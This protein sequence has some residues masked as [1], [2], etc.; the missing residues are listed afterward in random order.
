MIFVTVNGRSAT[1]FST[2]AITT[3]SRGVKVYFRFSAAWADL[4]KTAIF[5][6]GETKE[7]VELTSDSCVLPAALLSEHQ[8][9]NWLSVGVYG[10][11]PGKAMPSSIEPVCII[12]EGARPIC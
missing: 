6:A 1:A 11:D 10:T 2:D 9:G 5:Y 12:Q 4:A 8:A 3:G 7:E